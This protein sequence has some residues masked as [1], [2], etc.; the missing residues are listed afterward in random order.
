VRGL[1]VRPQ[2]WITAT[3][4]AVVACVLGTAAWWLPAGALRSDTPEGRLSL[5]AF[6][7]AAV[8]GAALALLLSILLTRILVQPLNEIGDFASGLSAGD[9]DRRL[10][11]RV[12]GPLGR[13]AADLDR[14]ADELRR[15]ID[16]ATAEKEQLQAV[17]GSMVEGVLVVNAAGRIVLANPRLREMLGVWGDV[18]GRAPLEVIRHAGVDDAMRA[19]A[20]TS[21]VVAH[22]IQLGGG[23]GRSIRL[24]AVAFPQTGPRLGTVAVFHDM[25]D[26]RRLEAV[27]RDF[28][29]NVSHELKTPLTA[30]R[31]FAETLLSV[32]VPL[33]DARKYLGVILRHAER[34]GNL[35]DDLLDL[36]RIES[37]KLPIKPIEVDVGRVAAAV[38]AG[39]ELQLRAK[40]LSVKLVE[41]VTPAAWA[42]RRAVDQ[43]LT[44]LLDNAAKY[45]HA[46]GHI[47]VQIEPEAEHIRVEVRD[48]GVGIPKEDLPRIFERFYR[49]EKARSRDLGGTGLGLAIVKHLVQSMG[50]EIYVESE[51]GRGSSFV[52]LL[53]RADR[54]T[55]A[56]ERRPSF[57]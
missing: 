24:H 7:V 51:I 30:I 9:L 56:G 12:G 43:I 6:E 32:D 34:L 33:D 3:L 2:L 44:N 16:E 11:W 50:G 13:I 19:A 21:D 46:G 25:T 10:R 20:S 48:D 23:E 53:P 38:I 14:M 35:I 28:V 1:P 52:I 54:L 17:L 22:E 42:D 37:R 55:A 26:L 4:L 36:S 27:R 47:E 41:G 57:T 8:L 15:R 31:G 5:H 18:V 49:V 40:M 39:M 45:T 29:A